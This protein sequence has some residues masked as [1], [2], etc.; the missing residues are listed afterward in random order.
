MYYIS[1]IALDPNGQFYDALYQKRKGHVLAILNIQFC[2]LCKLKGFFCYLSVRENIFYFKMSCRSGMK[3][4]TSIL[5]VQKRVKINVIQLQKK[6]SQSNFKH[7]LHPLYFISVVFEFSQK[8]KHTTVLSSCISEFFCSFCYSYFI[9]FRIYK[10]YIIY[11]EI[12]LYISWA[13]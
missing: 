11:Q 2:Q 12:S 13:L 6:S 5:E 8:I 1:F 7:Y 10:N 4:K 9:I 3:Q